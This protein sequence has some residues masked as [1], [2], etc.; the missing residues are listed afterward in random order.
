M[1]LPDELATA[2]EAEEAGELSEIIRE[3][4]RKHFESLCRL[5][6]GG[7]EVKA[8]YR[9]KAIYALGRWGD[10]RIVDDIAKV[11][12]ALAEAGRIA[13]IDALGRLGTERAFEVVAECESDVSPQV[14][15]MV[16]EACGRIG[17]PRA[18]T[19]LRSIAKRDAEDW[20]RSLALKRIERGT[21]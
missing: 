9:Q 20:I 21:R 8:E 2:L 10:P 13:A 19:R 1:S 11:L 12:P 4:R 6:F 16:V 17:G 7:P 3:R 15:K 18:E 5:A 14:R